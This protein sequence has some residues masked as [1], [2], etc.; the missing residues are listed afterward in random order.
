MVSSDLVS[1]DDDEHEWIV[2]HCRQGWDQHVGV[3]SPSPPEQEQPEEVD[4]EDSGKA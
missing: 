1:L 2:K 3:P 4:E